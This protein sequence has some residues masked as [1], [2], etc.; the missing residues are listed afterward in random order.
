MGQTPNTPD[1]KTYSIPPTV[2]EP[3]S[4][5]FKGRSQGADPDTSVVSEK[6]AFRCVAQHNRFKIQ[7][8]SEEELETEDYGIAPFVSRTYICVRISA[9]KH[10]VI[11]EVV[12]RCKHAEPTQV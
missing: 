4:Q 10:E 7:E 11:E 12:C 1:S 3:V 2:A 9:D 6:T 5:V 8:R